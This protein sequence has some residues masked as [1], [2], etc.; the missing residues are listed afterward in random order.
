[1]S[2]GQFGYW[3]GQAHWGKGLATAAA[4]A[5][6]RHVESQR[7]FA[8]LEARV[9]EWNHASMRVLEK[10][11]FVREGVLLKSVLKDNALIDSALYAYVIADAAD[12]DVVG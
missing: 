9:F 1:M 8:R 4:Q 10:A 2:N 11:G 7:L 5:L 12:S 3:L 6:V